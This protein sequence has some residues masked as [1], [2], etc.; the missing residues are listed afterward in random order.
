MPFEDGR[1]DLVLNR[2]GAFIAEDVARVLA[3][4]GVLLTQQVAGDDAHELHQLFGRGAPYPAHLR[5]ELI[6]KV[7]RAGMEV[8]EAAEWAGS[9][10]FRDVATL[11]AYLRIVP[12]DAPEDF[13]VDRSAD[14]LLALHHE[15]P[16]RDITLT[17]DRFWYRARQG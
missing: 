17:K 7:H 16:G 10:R 1:F 11:V 3:S 14:P 2:H 8:A 5:D 4:G 6:G 9:Y 12:R 15:Q 13:T